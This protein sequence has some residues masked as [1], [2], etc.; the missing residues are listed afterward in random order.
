M[1]SEK[2]RDR[3]RLMTKCS[4]QQ[5][6][7][8]SGLVYRWFMKI[9]EPNI[10]WFL[11]ERNGMDVDRKRR[12]V[13]W[14]ED[15]MP[16]DWQRKQINTIKSQS[17]VRKKYITKITRNGTSHWKIPAG[18]SP[19]TF[20]TRPTSAESEAPIAGRNTSGVRIGKSSA[21]QEPRKI[22]RLNK[23]FIKTKIV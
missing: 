22:N 14:A 19:G 12:P 7:E 20:H 13:T 21:G 8:P 9:I 18:R 1:N 16:A 11:K 5:G 23:T 15:W 2:L 10:C 3:T 17:V 6:S 4:K